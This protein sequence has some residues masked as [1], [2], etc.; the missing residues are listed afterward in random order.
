M[1]RKDNFLGKDILTI[2]EWGKMIMGLR[3]TLPNHIIACRSELLQDKKDSDCKISK[4][5]S[6]CKKMFW[7][8]R[9]F[10]MLSEQMHRFGGRGCESPRRQFRALRYNDMQ[11]IH[12]DAWI[13]VLSC[14]RKA[15]RIMRS[16]YLWTVPSQHTGSHSSYS[17]KV[18]HSIW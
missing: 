8:G 10:H 9:T 15:G 6:C 5:T 16:L 13:Q 4:N 18:A 2:K 17:T 7:L 14:L 11:S 1:F 3:A 12:H